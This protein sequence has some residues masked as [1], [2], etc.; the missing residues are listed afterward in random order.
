VYGLITGYNFI[1]GGGEK[2]IQSGEY[3]SGGFT[4]NSV[5]LQSG[6]I[7][8]SGIHIDE[9]RVDGLIVSVIND[10]TVAETVQHTIEQ[11]VVVGGAVFRFIHLPSDK[12]SYTAGTGAVVH[13]VPK[14][15]TGEAEQYAGGILPLNRYVQRCASVFS[16]LLFGIP[17]K[18][19]ILS[20]AQVMSAHRNKII[21]TVSGE[22]V[23][24][25]V[26]E[27]EVMISIE[28]KQHIL[29]TVQYIPR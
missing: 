28:Y 8:E 1:V 27:Y 6:D 17:E 15:C 20:P 13:A 19:R 10:F 12:P 5:S 4:D 14:G 22:I 18:R 16:G 29:K 21:V 3:F 9:T 23:D 25:I 7:L 2:G 24:T 11:A 26:P